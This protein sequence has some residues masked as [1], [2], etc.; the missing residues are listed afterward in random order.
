MALINFSGLASGIDTNSLIDAM[1]SATRAQK[2]DP[3]NERITELTDTNTALETLKTKFNELKDSLYNFTTLSGGGIVKTATSTNEAY[4]GASASNAASNGTYSLNVTQLA[5]NGTYAYGHSF[6]ASTDFVATTAGGHAASGTI[7][8]EVGTGASKETISVDITRDST[9]IAQFVSQFN[10]QAAAN[11]NCAQ[12]SLLNVGTTASPDYRVMISSN[13]TGT[14]LGTLTVTSNFGFL[15]TA[16][17]GG[18]NS[19]AQNA[20]FDLNGVTGITRET[21]SVSDAVT[22]V[23]FSLQG[24]GSASVTVADDAKSTETKIQDWVDIYN[25][26]VEYISEN[27]NIVRDESGSE[28]KNVFQPLAS[29]ST[30]NTALSSFRDAISSITSSIS[31]SGVN[32]LADLGITTQRD[33]T[34]KFDKTQ[35]ETAM[36]TSSSSV[37]SI[38]QQFADTTASTGGTIDTFIRFQGSFDVTI[39]SNK[40]MIERMTT[41]ISDAERSIAEQEEA[42]R[43]RFARLE[44]MMSKMQSQQSALVSA[45]AGLSG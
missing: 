39:T 10:E 12:A 32:I 20:I 31:G 17:P 26:L 6:G 3:L 35:F 38:M 1:S 23:T 27:N 11:G 9:T 41:Q 4:V 14:T 45:L 42:L 24:I 21:N 44:S 43:A 25:D 2:V 29:T 19:A 16:L 7:T 18:V 37:N 28:I 22:G 5:K 8:V 36:S 15:D 40:T 34:L 13:N 30:D 33:G